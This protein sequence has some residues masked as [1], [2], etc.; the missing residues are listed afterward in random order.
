MKSQKLFC[1]PYVGGSANIIYN[2]WRRYLDSKITLIPVEF[3]GHGKRIKESFSKDIEEL[4]N[5]LFDTIIESEIAECTNY[6]IYGHSMG[7]LVIYEL[8]KLIKAKNYSL[9]HTIFLSGRYSPNIIYQ[10]ENVHLL[11]DEQLI[12]KLTG[13]GGIPLDVLNYP[14]LIYPFIPIIRNDYKLLD[15][16]EFSLPV[17]C[18]DA[19]IIFTYSNN[20]PYLDDRKKVDEWKQYT[21]KNFSV[22]E[23]EGDHFF[24]KDKID[25]LCR[26]INQSAKRGIKP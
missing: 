23:V 21:S 3:P 22:F 17:S 2:G 8:L 4:V 20:D 25:F 26:L 18:F 16:Y 5:D 24:L 13:L 9:P 11:T 6:M 1:I 12:D 10:K 19:D 7:T 15:E 14:E